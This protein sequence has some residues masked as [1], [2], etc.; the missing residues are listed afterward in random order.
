MTMC[1]DERAAWLLAG[2]LGCVLLV[3][4]MCAVPSKADENGPHTHRFADIQDTYDGFRY[5][6][7]RVYFNDSD[8]DSIRT[9]CGVSGGDTGSRNWQAYLTDWNN[10]KEY[11]SGWDGTM[12]YRRCDRLVN[13]VWIDQGFCGCDGNPETADPYDWYLYD[14]RGRMGN[15]IGAA[16]FVWWVDNTQ[17]TAFNK[18]KNAFLEHTRVSDGT[19]NGGGCGYGLI[20]SLWGSSDAFGY[21]IGKWWVMAYD[22][23]CAAAVADTN[24]FNTAEQDSAAALLWVLKSYMEAGNVKIHGPY[25]VA[26]PEDAN[27]GY[28]GMW[29]TTTAL[30]TPFAL[31]GTDVGG[32]DT[33]RV[34]PDNWDTAHNLDHHGAETDTTFMWHAEWYN[35]Y[36]T[37]TRCRDVYTYGGGTGG[38][39][40]YLSDPLIIHPW[41]MNVMYGR[42]LFDTH[43]SIDCDSYGYS[44]Y[45]ANYRRRLQDWRR[46]LMTHYLTDGTEIDQGADGFVGIGGHEIGPGSW[47]AGVPHLLSNMLYDVSEV[48]SVYFK[49]WVDN[50]WW[51]GELNAG[52]AGLVP[53]GAEIIWKLIS[54]EPE[55]TA[56]NVLRPVHATYTGDW[57]KDGNTSDFENPVNNHAASVTDWT[58]YGHEA[59][60]ESPNEFTISC[61]SGWADQHSPYGTGLNF[62]LRQGRWLNAIKSGVYDDANERSAHFEAFYRSGWS[63]NGL[64]IGGKTWERS[65]TYG[66]PSET[67]GDS[68]TYLLHVRENLAGGDGVGKVGY[69]GFQWDATDFMQRDGGVTDEVIRE[70][71]IVD[72]DYVVVHDRIHADT[73]S[74]ELSVFFQVAHP[75]EPTL[76][77]GSY[78]SDQPAVG[79]VDQNTYGGTPGTIS[80]DATRW[81]GKAVDPVNWGSSQNANGPRTVFTATSARGNV[82]GLK[83]VG[84][85]SNV[86]KWNAGSVT[87]RTGE[88]T[89]RYGGVH[90]TYPESPG[91][92]YRADASVSDRSFGYYNP[93]RGV[94]ISAATNNG[95]KTIETRG[96]RGWWRMETLISG[97]NNW[98]A[99]THVLE[100]VLAA[101]VAT[102]ATVTRVYSDSVLAGRGDLPNF[103]GVLIVNSDTDSTIVLFNN[104]GT[105]G[106]QIIIEGD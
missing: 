2:I 54:G 78:D 105:V 34:D 96:Q 29:L 67:F 66:G 1:N 60:R 98:D 19:V 61:Y 63:S 12:E 35:E 44:G 69:A 74:D 21:G 82:R 56:S 104:S 9:W 57:P 103:S 17:T 71:A 55:Q 102:A 50:V 46:F 84:G 79:G 32:G 99:V 81:W 59:D 89:D 93:E 14:Y 22:V 106:N 95:E 87:G 33:L 49:W 39:T 24:D 38:Y 42:E 13:Q 41:T 68:H 88:A 10:L 86:N 92:D 3:A 16:A 85:P 48:A 77:D 6:R 100:P 15:Y 72:G 75:D 76:L 101:G 25:D 47:G 27:H 36:I 30:A 65:G 7:P 11:V 8:L 64:A 45:T 18:A 73:A 52:G 26:N 40:S 80:S 31:I 58:D 43:G 94:Q 4:L 53:S 91:G 37:W 28:Y 5:D 70:V 51:G 62:D 97:G 20:P 23:L 83:L 90:I